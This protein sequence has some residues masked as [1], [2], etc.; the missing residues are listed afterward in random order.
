[1]GGVV[2]SRIG[3][4]H[5]GTPVTRAHRVCGLLLGEREGGGWGKKRKPHPTPELE[6][7][8]DV[9]VVKKGDLHCNRYNKD[10]ETTVQLKHHIELYHTNVYSHVC[11][12]C[13]KGLHS[14]T[15]LREHMKV[16]KGGKVQCD[17][18]DKSFTT[19]RAKKCHMRDIHGKKKNLKCQYCGHVSHTPCTLYLHLKSCPK[20]PHQISLYCELCTKGLW[21]TGSKVLE[22][23][24]KD[25]NW[26]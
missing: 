5:G 6:I 7:D 1:M 12:V 3:R 11:S 15:G 20:N 10:F 13:D 8:T 9:Q 26:K 21:Y 2:V 14:L 4:A 25:H 17:K 18:C 19:D 22:H 24:R 23:K 16:H